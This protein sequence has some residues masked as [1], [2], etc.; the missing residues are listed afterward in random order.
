VPIGPIGAR[1]AAGL[2][3][4]IALLLGLSAEALA[5]GEPLPDSGDVTYDQVLENPDDIMLSY[6]FALKQIG[7]GDLLGASATLDRLTLLAPQESN[8]RALRAIVLYR[9]G[10][11]RE[12]KDEFEDLL[13]LDV[14]P[15]LRTNIERYADA[16]DQQSQ[17]TRVNL[18]LSMGYQFDSNRA[19][20][21][22]VDRVRT[23]V[24]SFELNNAAPTE[25]DHSIQ[26]L[27]RLS[28]EHDLPGQDRHMLFGNVT[29]YDGDQ[30]ELDDFDT[31]TVG[32]QAGIRL[33]IGE[34]FVTPN[35]NYNHLWLGEESYVDI[36]QPQVRYDWRLND[37]I[38]L[39]GTFGGAKYE[40]HGTP[41]YPEADIQSGLDI[42]ATIGA[43]WYIGADHKLTLAYTHRRFDA[44]V[45]FESFDGDR[46]NLDHVWLLGHGIFLV[47]NASV[48]WDRYDAL[49]PVFVGDD[50]ED[51]IYR[52][53]LTLGVPVAT[54]VGAE[55][56]GF[57]EGLLMTTY[58][59][60]YR[61]DSNS[62]LYEFENIRGGI[63][64][65]KRF[66]F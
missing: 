44:E 31:Q 13:K 60:Y 17:D 62:D 52:G 24:G 51:V 3:G 56:T 16:I 64:V 19:G 12:A 38:N 22:K 21:N 39:F 10:N 43:D 50:R 41:D 18:L 8:I 59:E 34:L 42:A 65:S 14:D 25:D 54:M 5:Q 11:L 6:R 26:A 40:Y 55:Q 66:Q 35:I 32:A 46:L 58:G 9:L 57:L 7:D 29:L 1:G 33:E 61:Q 15:Q 48:E 23:V 27:A 2:C 4:A 45:E 20:G 30:I 36:I 49:D 37:P 28:V 63:A 47:T 53:R